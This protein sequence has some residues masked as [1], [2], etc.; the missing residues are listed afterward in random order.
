MYT[1]TALCYVTIYANQIM[2]Y[3][4]L[5]ELMFI[6]KGTILVDVL[7]AAGFQHTTVQAVVAKGW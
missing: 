5:I 6:S 1:I 3:V 4:L 7:V 2:Y